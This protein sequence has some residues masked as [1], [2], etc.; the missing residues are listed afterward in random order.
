MGIT[1]T[2]LVVLFIGVYI[3]FGLGMSWMEGRMKE[4]ES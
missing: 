3:G 2:I 1:M 4:K